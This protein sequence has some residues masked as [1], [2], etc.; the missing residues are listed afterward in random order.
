MAEAIEY[1]KN[2]GRGVAPFFDEYDI[3]AE[4]TIAGP[5]WVSGAADPSERQLRALQ[6]LGRMPGRTA[7]RM[8]VKKAAA[9]SLDVIPNTPLWNATGQPSMSVPLHWADGLPIGVQFTAR[10]GEESLLFCLASQ[11]ENARPWNH[12]LPPLLQG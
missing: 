12:R 1:V 3:F 11:L 5:P 6:T 4:S 8:A 2:I 7:V 9:R 10:Y